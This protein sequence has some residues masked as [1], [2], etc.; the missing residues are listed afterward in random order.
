MV[1][2]NFTLQQTREEAYKRAKARGDTAAARALLIE[3]RKEREER[4]GREELR[5]RR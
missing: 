1:S 5:K 4:E 3:L 2:V